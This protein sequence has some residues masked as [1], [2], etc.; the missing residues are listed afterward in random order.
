MI[1]SIFRNPITEPYIIGL[2]SGAALGAVM[3]IILGLT[4]LGLYT[5]QLL[6]FIFAMASVI[7]VYMF[8]LRGG[9]AHPTYMLLTGVA[10]SFFL[11]AIVAL[12]LFSNINLEDEAFFWLLGS[13]ENINWLELFPVSAVVLLCSILLGSQY[14][15]LDALQMGDT[16][17]RSVGVNVER[18]KG[19][20]IFLVAL[21][22]SAS[23]S[24][25]GLIGF[26]GLIMP[27]VSRII[28]GGSNRFVLPGPA[29]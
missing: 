19:M 23:V 20:S 24:I 7:V 9:K 4:F 27:H 15:E 12:L 11:S 8:A 10:L 28:F 14:R 25:S 2:S 29:S 13:L 16:H 17:A 3:T 22:V 1:Q 5:Q 21:S 6:A 18:T 26:V